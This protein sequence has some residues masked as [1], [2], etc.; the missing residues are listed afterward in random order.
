[1]PTVDSLLA[2]ERDH[3]Q[4][5]PGI[6]LAGVDE[7]GRGPLAGPVVAAAVTM[8]PAVAEDLY[9]GTLSGLTDSKQLAAPVREACY[10]VLAGL[11]S[12]GIGVGWAEAAEIDELNILYATHLAMRRALLALPRQPGW[13]LI[14]GKP[15][16]GMPCA[17]T[18]IVQGDAKCFLVAAASVVAK[19]LR[20]R[21]MDELDRLYPQYGFASH[22]GYGTHDHVVA[23][24]R[25]GACP[26]HRRSFR[27]VQDALQALPG[28]LEQVV[29]D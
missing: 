1:M 5:H 23:L 28:V 29:D 27:P 2:Y 18:A 3:W 26:E 4:A 10:D 9:G 25:H 12:V 22:K 15:V 24:F 21:R 8:D 17:Y 16:D 13:A 11:P 19:V 14:D 7:A 20:D 6:V